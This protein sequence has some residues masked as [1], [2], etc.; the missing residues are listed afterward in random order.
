[1]RLSKV[2]VS[3]ESSQRL[4]MLSQR[5]GLKPNLSC[6]L[7]FCL[8][9]EEAGSPTVQEFGGTGD[10]E[11]NWSTLFGQWDSLFMALLRQR[12]VQDGLDPET[13]LDQQLQLHLNRGVFILFKRLRK[14]EGLGQLLGSGSAITHDEE[15]DP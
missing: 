9:L 8:S 11:F 3:T 12:L 2:Y 13:D 7:G 5:T 10:R 15:I 14:L 1:M 6:R 4:S